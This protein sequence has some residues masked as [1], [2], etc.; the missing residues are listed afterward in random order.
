MRRHAD[1][2]RYDFLAGDDRYK[3][4]LG[5]A[6]AKLGWLEVGGGWPS[7]LLARWAR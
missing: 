5:T 4:S 3:R 1:F 2:A 6:E 7:R